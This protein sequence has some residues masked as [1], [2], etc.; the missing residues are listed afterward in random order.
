[1]GMALSESVLRSYERD[2]VLSPLP[3]LGPDEVAWFRARAEEL[4][5]RLRGPSGAADIVQPQ[6]HFRWAYD[7]ATHP[8]VLDAVSDVIGQDVLVHSAS[9][10]SKRPGDGR[11]V[12]WHQ[13]GHYWRLSM[14]KLVSAWIALSHSTRASGCLR[15]V[16]G[17]HR[18]RLPHREIDDPSNMLKSG[19][20]LDADVD[21]ARVVDIYLAPGQMS[22]HHERIVHGSGP[23]RS[24]DARIGFAV[25]YAAPEVSQE[26]PHHAVILARGRDVYAHYEHLTSPPGEDFEENLERHR[27]FAEALRRL[28]LGAS[29]TPAGASR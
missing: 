18:D 28:R 11:H 7:L 10:F 17:T 8:R 5:R 23:N 29:R 9:L 4:E 3:A 21:P 27:T 1:M 22:L 2:G 20:T 15:V 19:L 14:A 6:L 12:P 13:D 24:T 26:L 16:P 25:R